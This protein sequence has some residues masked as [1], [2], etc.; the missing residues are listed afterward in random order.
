MPDALVH[1]TYAE[2]VESLTE[3]RAAERARI[4]AALPAALRNL[5]T[6]QNYLGK[7]AEE[8]AAAL[9]AAIEAQLATPTE[10]TR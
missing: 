5:Y 3:E 8:D 4:F 1:I 6:A 10:V 7:G 2:Y 9:V